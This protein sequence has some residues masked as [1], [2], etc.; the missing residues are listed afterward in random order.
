MEG[1]YG[2]LLAAALPVCA[3]MAYALL[4][5]ALLPL[6]AGYAQTAKAAPSSPAAVLAYREAA[7]FQNNGAFEIAA[8]EWQKFLKAHPNDPLASKGQHYL[9]VC[10][11]QLKQHAAAAATFQAV[12]DKYPQFE[13]LDD[14]YFDLAT[15]QYALA[16]GGDK[17]LYE[18][19]AKS[20]AALLDRSPQT[21]HR[22]ESLF[23]QG[24][25]LYALGK[26]ADAAKSYQ[27]LLS[28]FRDSKRRADALYALGVAQEELGEN[29]SAGKT[30]DAL[31]REFPDHALASEVRLRK[32]ETLLQ[33]GDVAAAER[34]FAQVAAAKD[35]A[36]TDHALSRQAYCL[37][38]LD[39]FADGAK[40]YARLVNQY[41]RSELA[42]D[43]SISAGRLFYR[44][45]DRPEARKW[46]E[47]ALAQRDEHAAEAAHWLC[48]L[49]IKAGDSQ[50]AVDL[51]DKQLSQ[52]SGPFA[53][54]LELDMADALY[55]LPARRGEAFSRYVD[56]VK[57]HREHELTPQA[58]YS[59]AFAALD[60]KRYKEALQYAEQFLKAYPRHELDADVKYVAAESQL[61]LKDYAAAAR[62][63]RDL[64]GQFG[65]RPEV[66]TWKLRFGHA[67]LLS[68]EYEQVVTL[69][70]PEVKRQRSAENQ[71][72]AQYLIGSAQF[73]AGR[74]AEAA[75]A[76]ADSIAKNAK[77]AHV[78]DALLLLARA[79]F[80]EGK[81][82]DAERNLQRLLA[83]HAGSGVAVEAHFRL[84]E[85]LDSRQKLPEAKKE[86]DLVERQFAD[87]RFAPYAIYGRGWIEFKSKEYESA[88]RSFTA[89]IDNGSDR[90]LASKALLGRAMS[91]RQTG[92]SRE[93]IADLDKYLKTDLDK[94]QRSEALYERGLAL[95]ALNDYAQAVQTLESLLK[96]N[97]QYAG[98]DRVLY[99]I[100]WAL[101]NQGKDG[102][103][104]ARFVQLTKQYGKSSLAPE[105]WFHVAEQYYDD[106]KYAEA[107]KAYASAKAKATGELAEKS[108]YKLAWTRFQEQNYAGA[109]QTF[110]E[111][112]QQF[113]RGELAADAIFMKAE[114]LFR[115]EKFAEAWPAYEA[116]LATKPSTPT[117]QALLLLHAGQTAAQLKNWNDGAKLIAQVIEQHATSPLVAEAQYELGWIRQ[118][119]GQSENALAAYEQAATLS[120]D[121]VGARARFMRGELLF[122]QKKH[123]EAS[124]EF[125]RSMYGYGGDD[126]SAETK[127]WQAKSGY[128]AGRCAEVQ[129]N[130]ATAA[131]DKQ[132]YS[133]DARRFYTF[134]ADKHAENSLAAEAKK[135]LAIV[136]KLSIP[137][138]KQR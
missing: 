77:A 67:L 116:A 1:K 96:R 36:A 134:V 56:F 24:E 74:Y 131:A 38:K 43:A 83:E 13:L 62:S 104:A 105:A 138:G 16:V 44:A 92:D 48:R 41:P 127:N 100:G 93:A 130:M 60:L 45:D 82:D 121:H 17:R 55:E 102:E 128:E 88:E 70:T 75:Q 99:E 84:G 23:Y 59:A 51:A 91:R 50:A 61:Q 89:V 113:P 115:Q 47:R 22:E 85:L 14:A 108:L 110:T 69:L 46:L 125:Q 9:G 42:A 97:P 95:V 31:L 37:A 26:K 79:Q 25:A 129:L 2:K 12:I 72:D 10:Q 64:I 76:L 101:K 18:Q 123:A 112:L 119:Q 20:Y 40:A 63:Y 21:K 109:L 4:A 8:E 66:E 58:T 114:C 81:L 86:Y 136:N 124:H 111:Q 94:A 5:C 29:Q 30:Y 90:E 71:A 106:Q 33:S 122:E 3:L 103:A 87:S 57:K 19:A 98:A 120:R 132:K 49:L 28:E 80:K 68:K 126:A 39:R 107:G 78:D 34:L 137:I 52:G 11:L 6:R 65:S 54:Q 7:N 35:F 32:A 118:N 117:A 135:R 133:A 53:T 73:Q 27:S 15:S